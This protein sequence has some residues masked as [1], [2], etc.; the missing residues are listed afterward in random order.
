MSQI[1]DFTF[2]VVVEQNT[3]FYVIQIQLKATNI[4]I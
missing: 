2:W 4:I 3:S 1:D